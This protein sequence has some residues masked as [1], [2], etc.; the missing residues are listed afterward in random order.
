MQRRWERP[1]AQFACLLTCC[2]A[3][4]VASSI[5]TRVGPLHLCRAG[6]SILLPRYPT[7]T[8]AGPRRRIS[9]ALGAPRVGFLFCA[10]L[11]RGPFCSNINR[12]DRDEFFAVLDQLTLSEIEARLPQWDDQQLRLVDEYLARGTIKPALPNNKGARSLTPAEPI[13]VATASQAYKLATIALIIA[14]GAM[15]TAIA[16]GLVAFQALLH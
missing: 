3:R 12:V 15:T 14:I 9:P 7:V 5:G 6:V 4:Q 13:R 16:A 2:T 8:P 11:G 1:R 10:G